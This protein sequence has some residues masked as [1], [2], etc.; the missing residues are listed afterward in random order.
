MIKITS[1]IEYSQLSDSILNK[2]QIKS[3]SG[4]VTH[5][6]NPSHTSH[7]RRFNKNNLELILAHFAGIDFPRTISTKTTEGRQVLVNDKD[8]ALAR[9]KQANYLDCRINAYTELDDNPNFIFIDIDSND[10]SIVEN[11]LILQKLEEW[12]PTVLFTGSGYHIYQPV[13]SLRLEDIADFTSYCEPSRKFLKFA[14]EYLSNGKSDPNHNP[15]F[16]S[17]MVRVPGSINS[18]NGN[19]VRLIQEWNGQRP[20]IVPLL[21]IFYS[22]L[23]TKKIGER[24]SDN[25]FHRISSSRYNSIGWIE[26]VLKTPLDDY[27]KT[28]VNLVLAPYLTN[29]RQLQY[30]DA[31]EIIKLWLEL[32]ANCRKLDFNTHYLINNALVNAGKTGYKP[33]RLG[34]L[35]E[36]NTTIYEMLGMK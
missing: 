31:F 16:K 5:I 18:K 34:T 32:S 19:E 17:C 24:A 2:L 22:W 4:T 20:D 1:N 36:R 8:E 10:F 11:F 13:E 35:K 7:P 12:H 15:S 26:K 6:Y 25:N 23:A 21:G 28:I 27:R 30:H 3:E 9:F 29:V 33:M 14:P